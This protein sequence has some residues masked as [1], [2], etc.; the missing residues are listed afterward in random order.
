MNPE[1]MGLSPEQMAM[2]QERGMEPP[3]EEPPIDG[4]MENP[5]LA[6]EQMEMQQNIQQG[7]PPEMMEQMG[8][9][10]QSFD[11]SM[12]MGQEEQG[13]QMAN[14]TEILNDVILE[15]MDFV[16][17]IKNDQQL[18]EQV[19]SKIMAEQ[20]SAISS[21][22]PLLTNSADME[23]TKMRHEMD[24]KYQ[25]HEMDMQLKQQE[26]A[27]K[28]QEMEMNLQFK[29]QEQQVKLQ[30]QKEQS[31]MKLQQQQEQHQTKLVQGQESH[32]TKI[33]QQKQ[34]AQVKQSSNPSN[35]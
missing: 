30:M 8:M 9:G 20:A 14:P 7:M 5:E 10:Q 27:M 17:G 26:M 29:A 19:R 13:N 6:P 34:A 15:F 33:E 3:V 12:L 31:Q 4:E 32:E 11:P 35:D 2:A 18:D 21:L 28:K 24:L 1:E 25:E 22:V 23:L 16:I